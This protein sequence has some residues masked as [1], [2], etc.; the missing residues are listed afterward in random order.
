MSVAK[1]DAGHHNHSRSYGSRNPQEYRDNHIINNQILNGTRRQSPLVP[2]VVAAHP[3]SSTPNSNDAPLV[4]ER[5]PDEGAFQSNGAS[6]SLFPF[7]P[8]DFFLF[9]SFFPFFLAFVPAPPTSGFGSI[10]PAGMVACLSKK[11]CAADIP[12]TD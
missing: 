11:T 12:C 1:D 9:L 8:P 4:V 7:P 10:R 2:A 5:I 3:N 6:G